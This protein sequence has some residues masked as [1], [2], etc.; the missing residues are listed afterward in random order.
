MVLRCAFAAENALFATAAVN[1]LVEA[2]TFRR[3][4]LQAGI[5]LYVG[6][7]AGGGWPWGSRGF[8]G[9]RRFGRRGGFR[10]VRRFGDAVGSGEVGV[11]SA[12]APAKRQ[13]VGS[14]WVPARL[15]PSV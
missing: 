13:E 2:R 11:G 15:G 9:D 12:E 5:G 14:Q 7:G 10:R 6:R 8:R 3:P 4:W 1:V